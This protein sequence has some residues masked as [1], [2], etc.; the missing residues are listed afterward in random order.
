MGAGDYGGATQIKKTTKCWG[1]GE[2]EGRYRGGGLLSRVEPRPGTKGPFVPGGGFTR[3]KRP[4][5]IFPSSLLRPSP[6]HLFLLVPPP[7]VPLLPPPRELNVPEHRRRRR[8]E[9]LRAP[10]PLTSAIPAPA[11]CHLGFAAPASTPRARPRLRRP[12]RPPL[13]TAA[14]PPSPLRATA[15]P[16]PRLVVQGRAAPLARFPRRPV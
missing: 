4:P 15:P 7:S 1:R 5:H 3:D 8:P 16:A 12:R 6:K 10:P 9:P 14:P 11:P 13:H 2:E